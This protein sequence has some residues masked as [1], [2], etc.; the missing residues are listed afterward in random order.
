MNTRPRSQ[1]RNT[2]GTDPLLPALIDFARA[3]DGV[4]VLWLYGSRAKGTAT[5]ES[6]Y[7]LAVAFTGAPADRPE[8]RLR[9][10]LLALDWAQTLSLPEGRLSVVDI[11]LAPLP[12]AMAVIT[13]GVVLWSGNGLRLAREENRVMGMWELDY[14]YHRRVYG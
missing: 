6:D 2:S 4:E 12:L 13:Q 10:E 3:V 5:A 14:Q 7:D 9:P 1:T 8:R 11:N